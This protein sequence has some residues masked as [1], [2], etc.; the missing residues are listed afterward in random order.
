MRL[1]ST[2]RVGILALCLGIVTYGS[3]YLWVNTRSL[4][5]V[6]IPVTLGPGH[7]QTGNFRIDV[8]ANYSIQ[9]RILHPGL[10]GC[11]EG[12]GLRT[13]RLTVIGGQ[14]ISTPG[15]GIARE[16]GVEIGTYLGSFDGRPGNYNLDIEVLSAPQYLN[17]CG[18]RLEIEA[19]YSDFDRWNSREET[20]FT[21]GVFCELLGSVLLLVSAGVRKREKEFEESR[22][23]FSSAVASSSSSPPL[24]RRPSHSIRLLLILG[25]VGVAEGLIAIAAELQTMSFLSITVGLAFLVAYRS[26]KLRESPRALPLAASLPEQKPAWGITG[27]RYRRFPA[28]RGWAMNPV[29]NIPTIALVCS[30]TWFTCFAPMWIGYATGQGWRWQG[31]LVSLPRKGVPAVAIAPG[32]TAPLVSIDAKRHVFLNYKETTWEKLPAGLERAFRSQPVRVV[33]FEGDPDALFME[34]ARAIDIIEREGAKAILV[35]PGSKA[36]NQ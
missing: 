13:R 6:D 1:P 16:D 35:T 22:L 23:R 27:L 4:S 14:R 17:S 33:Y 31:L 7:I 12:S 11:D 21:F 36:E 5:P 25:I 19:S 2:A 15:A 3:V 9:I 8:E 18:P 34:A 28:R 10:P 32:L 24:E 26:G 30:L 29:M 20:A